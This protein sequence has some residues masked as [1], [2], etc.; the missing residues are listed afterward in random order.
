MKI[1]PER[2]EMIP[3]FGLRA[4][5]ADRNHPKQRRLNLIEIE[6]LFSR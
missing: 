2:D 1:T 6:G 5:E 4:I 3:R